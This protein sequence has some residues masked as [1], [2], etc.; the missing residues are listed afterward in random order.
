VVVTVGLTIWLPPLG[1]RVYELPSLP[2]IVTAVELVA[3]TVNVDD[4]PEIID[5]GLALMLT[6][7]AAGWVTVTVALAVVLPPA[8]VAVAV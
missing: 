2:L 3:V 7:G 4:L 6:V 8:P 5:A 1:C